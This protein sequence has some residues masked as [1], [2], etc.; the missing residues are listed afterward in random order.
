MSDLQEDFPYPIEAFLNT[1]ARMLTHK[2]ETREISLLAS[3]SAEIVLDDYDNWNGG[4]YTWG[5]LLKVPSQVLGQLGEE[6]KVLEARLLELASSLLDGLEEHTI[7]RFVLS[8]EVTLNPDWRQ[9]AM[10]WVAGEGVNNQGRVR[11]S[12]VAAKQRDG[13]LFRS[14]P[15]INLYEAIKPLGITLAPLPVFVRGG[16][17][18]GRIEPDFLM[19]KSGIAMLVEIDGDFFHHESPADALSRVR[20]LVE[21]GVKYE[22]IKASDC[23][24]PEKAREQALRILKL[25]EKYATER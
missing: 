14:Q 15:E 17:T 1:M 4:Q 9:K 18:Y 24:S 25:L 13:L 16:K 8:P 7:R 20:M 21:E 19:I 10:R 11:S 12:N 22:R 2:A 23:D 3:S 5:I 6:R